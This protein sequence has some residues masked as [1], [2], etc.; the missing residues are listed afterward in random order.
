MVQTGYLWTVT[1]TR[2]WTRP[3]GMAVLVGVGAASLAVPPYASLVLVSVVLASLV[4]AV[5]WENSSP[6]RTG[7]REGGSHLRSQAS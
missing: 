7:A 2:T 3:A 6:A 1:H 4:A 5:L